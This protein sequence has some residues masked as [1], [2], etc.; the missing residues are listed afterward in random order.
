MVMMRSATRFS[1]SKVDAR[2]SAALVVGPEGGREGSRLR[3]LAEDLHE[4]VGFE[5]WGHTSALTLPRRRAAARPPGLR[6]RSTR[7]SLFG[8][9]LHRI[10]KQ[11]GGFLLITTCEVVGEPSIFAC[12]LDG[13]AV[14]HDL[15]AL[16][17]DGA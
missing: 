14:Q 6:T 1:F 7:S 8:A 5:L 17:P 13:V 2:S 12:H 9:F 16:H 15:P 4:R 10:T 11:A 3:V